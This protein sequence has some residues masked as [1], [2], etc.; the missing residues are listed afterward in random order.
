MA[1][2]FKLAKITE[3]AT[4]NIAAGKTLDVSG[5]DVSIVGSGT[6]VITF[7]SATS[8]LATTSDIPVSGTDF[9]PVGTDNS[10]NNA[11]N[12]LY[13]GLEA[14]KQDTLVNTT[15]IKS[16]NG[17]T[18]LGSGNLDV[19]GAVDSVNT[20]TGA[21][22]L[23][24]DDIDDTSTTN[25]YVT[26][27]D[28]TKLGNLSGENTG[29]QEG[30]GTTITGTGTP[31]DPFVS[32][33]TGDGDFL[34]DGSVPMTGRLDLATGTTTKAPIKLTAGTKLTTALAGALDFDGS[35]LF[36]TV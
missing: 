33:A 3:D 9:D 22:V 32:V 8:T 7:P 12:T 30:D 17:T 11:I 1:T 28:I 20:Q 23:D 18:L 35:N 31:A 19:G 6:A 26:A 29:D 34:A 24:A 2:R 13:S 15:N 16:V 5:A 21:V 14:S 4:L 36:L 27:G 25:K 10:D